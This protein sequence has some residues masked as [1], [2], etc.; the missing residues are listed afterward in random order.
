MTSFRS[1]PSFI[2]TLIGFL[3]NY[4]YDYFCSESKLSK[5]FSIIDTFS[6]DSDISTNNARYV[7]GNIVSLGD[8]TFVRFWC[9]TCES[10]KIRL[11]NK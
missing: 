9:V 3:N 5:L 10:C 6:E 8:D 1:I 7:F 11:I 2:F 4:S